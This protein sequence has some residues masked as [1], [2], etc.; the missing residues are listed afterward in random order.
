M[1]AAL[2]VILLVTLGGSAGK[3]LK[4][5]SVTRR[6]ALELLADSGATTVS[7]AAP[8]LFALVSTGKLTAIVPAGWRATA[9]AANGTTRAEFTDPKHSGST[10][11]IVAQGSSGEDGHRQA[12]AALK[13]VKK[14]GDAVSSYGPVTFPG[15]REAW[16]VTYTNAGL[17]N[18]T[19]FLAACRGKA[20]IVI[21]VA[22]PIAIFRQEQMTFG[23][24]AASAEPV[25]S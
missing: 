18:E 17:T 23:A 4:S 1:V 5:A 24:V 10:L 6:Q 9:Q 13:A 14:T 21:G 25:C 22:A 2:V 7:D 8:G 15:G 20:A 19:Y 12:A 16:Q 3:N 11:T